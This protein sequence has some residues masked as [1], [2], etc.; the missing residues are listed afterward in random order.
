[1]YE[2]LQDLR[3]KGDKK[4]IKKKDSSEEESKR[5]RRRQIKS[6]IWGKTERKE[7][8][9]GES[10]DVWLGLQRRSIPH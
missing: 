1:M 4:K 2:V 10:A 3:S 6:M 9:E 7:T 8:K 5:V